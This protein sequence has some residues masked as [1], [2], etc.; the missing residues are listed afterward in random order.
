MKIIGVM[1]KDIFRSLDV[2]RTACQ[3]ATF[4]FTVLLDMNLVFP[5]CINLQAIND[6]N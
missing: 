6:L 4:F 1:F 3:M 5:K 2:W